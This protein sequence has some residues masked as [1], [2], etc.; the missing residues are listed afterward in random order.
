MLRLFIFFSFIAPYAVAQDGYPSSCNPAVPNECIR[1]SFAYAALNRAPFPKDTIRAKILLEKGI[2][3]AWD[4]CRAGD[5]EHCEGLVNLVFYDLSDQSDQTKLSALE[6]ANKQTDAACAK[7]DIPACIH[8]SRIPPYNSDMWPFFADMEFYD[9]NQDA[10]A[11]IKSKDQYIARTPSM[12]VTQL[13]QSRIKTIS[14]ACNAGDNSA[15]QEMGAVF[16]MAQSPD[17]PLDLHQ[18]VLVALRGCLAGGRKACRALNRFTNKTAIGENPDEATRMLVADAKTAL[19]Q[20][21]ET[22]NTFACEAL[23]HLTTD[24]EKRIYFMEQ[25]CT[26]GLAEACYR[27]GS[28]EYNTF[29]NDNDPDTLQ[30]AVIYLDQACVQKYNMACHLLEHISQG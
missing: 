4:G 28:L 2:E 20:S 27:R 21:C 17:T 10:I 26:Q 16:W 14:P 22:A 7:G 30:K 9:R 25:A 29:R 11:A 12:R 8:N 6:L 1:I 3:G 23:I 24:A 18:L 5:S 15:C 13:A 19:T